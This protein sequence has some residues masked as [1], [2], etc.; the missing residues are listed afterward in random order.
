MMTE[1]KR[2]FKMLMLERNIATAKELARR[3]GLSRGTIANAIKGTAGAKAKQEIVNALRCDDLFPGFR[4]VRH[5]VLE[6]GS[7][8]Q[9]PTSEMTVEFL[10]EVGAAGV[11]VRKNLVK[12][13][14]DVEF[15]LANN[16]LPP[17]TPA[18]RKSLAQ[19]DEASANVITF[20]GADVES[21]A[22]AEAEALGGKEFQRAST[23]ATAT[24]KTRKPTGR[25]RNSSAR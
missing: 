12:L 9:W 7:L 23:S 24:T 6:A 19:A 11:E 16:P 1:T 20:W 14:D 2:K 10:R 13:L 18:T 17:G 8:V 5:P 3:T 25:S 4:A 21:E 22:I 15:G